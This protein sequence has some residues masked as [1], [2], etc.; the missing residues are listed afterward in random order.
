MKLIVP[1]RAKQVPPSIP[2]SITTQFVD[3]NGSSC[4][5]E[6]QSDLL[7]VAKADHLIK[8]QPQPQPE[9][10]GLPG[11]VDK[12]DQMPVHGGRRLFTPSDLLSNLASLVE[13]IDFCWYWN[14]DIGSTRRD[15]LGEFLNHVKKTEKSSEKVEKFSRCANYFFQFFYCMSRTYGIGTTCF[16][17]N[18]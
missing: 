10:V 13:E 8:D 4:R 7:I 2:S 3:S 5:A 15:V 11:Q 17:T 14:N 16:G 1:I 12:F 6:A 18:R 9:A